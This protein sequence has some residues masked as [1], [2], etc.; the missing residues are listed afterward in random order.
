MQDN[1]NEKLV[2]DQKK[3]EEL[4]VKERILNNKLNEMTGEYDQKIR[5]KNE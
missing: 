2:E 5:E 1:L 3:V 4:K